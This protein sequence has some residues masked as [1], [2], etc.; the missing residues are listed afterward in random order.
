MTTRPVKDLIMTGVIVLVIG[1]TLYGL[2]RWK[3]TKYDREVQE[4][5]DKQVAE[6]ICRGRTEA[7]WQSLEATMRDDRDRRAQA[8]AVELF[9]RT[10]TGQTLSREEYE[11][12]C[13]EYEIERGRRRDGRR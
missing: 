6:T 1:T 7:I 3:E 11:Q 4:A 2:Q 8:K 12:A 10:M 5:A 13:V 9:R